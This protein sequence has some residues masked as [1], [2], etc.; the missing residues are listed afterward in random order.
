VKANTQAIKEG[1]Y[2]GGAR[3]ASATP[4]KL[5]PVGNSAYRNAAYGMM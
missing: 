4:S 2:G 5:N 1:T 3:A